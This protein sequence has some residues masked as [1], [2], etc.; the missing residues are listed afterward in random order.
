VCSTFNADD[1]GSRQ[2]RP[3]VHSIH[4]FE[5]YT[6]QIVLVLRAGRYFDTAIV[7]IQP[8]LRSRCTT[9]DTRECPYEDKAF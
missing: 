8:L 5:W 3:L 2:A 9:P 1:A 7:Q 6:L 4:V